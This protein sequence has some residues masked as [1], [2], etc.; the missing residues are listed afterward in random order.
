M[1][2]A[3]VLIAGGVNQVVGFQHKSIFKLHVLVDLLIEEILILVFV[4][5]SQYIQV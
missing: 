1:L 5:Q 4:E 3:K 2:T